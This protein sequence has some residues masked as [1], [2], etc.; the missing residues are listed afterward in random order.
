M[1]VLITGSSGFIGTALIKSLLTKE[2]EVAGLS[3]KNNE[4]GAPYWLPECEEFDLGNFNA[5][6]VVIH[7]AG[8]S[9]ASGRWNAKKKERILQSRSQGTKVL[10]NFL[11][12]LDH[13]PHTLISGSA[14]GFYG[15]RGDELLD[16]TSSKGNGFLSTICK[17]WE[18]ACTP[19]K[20]A[21]IRVVNIRTGMVL[22][23]SGGALQKMILP[24]K[25][26]LGGVLGS[27]LQYMSWIALRDMVEAIEF[28]ATHETVRGPVNLVSPQPV[29]NREFTKALGK[30]LKRPTLFPVPAIVLRTMFGEIANELL[31]S[32]TRVIPSK[33]S[34][35][36]YKF[37]HTDLKP[38]LQS[39][40]K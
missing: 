4:T 3:R 9:I 19:A 24:F 37:Y 17:E 28:L 18:E 16:E 10:C 39:L 8:E 26:G 7:L 33:L 14:I 31:L 23:S 25:L 40:F 21:G 12:Q 35:G 32:S 20:N 5:P 29:T 34:T 38:T 30:A 1:K 27:G 22:S 13:K 36:G 6:D 2:H 15:D 11:S